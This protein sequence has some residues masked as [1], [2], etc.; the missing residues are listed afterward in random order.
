VLIAAAATRPPRA[1]EG[2]PGQEGDGEADEP[3]EDDDGESD[4]DG[5]QKIK[6]ELSRSS[7]QTT[8]PPKNGAPTLAPS[9]SLPTNSGV[10]LL[11]NTT[12]AFPPFP[13]GFTTKQDLLQAPLYLL[14]LKEAEYAQEQAAAAAA[15][16]GGG[17]P[18]PMY[19]A[20]H[21]ASRQVSSQGCSR[22][23]IIKGE[24]TGQLW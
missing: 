12:P 8:S 2:G 7:G 1:D 24:W 4:S 21:L 3:D 15:A 11:P 10:P 16:A 13:M 20:G 5:P 22:V 14:P 9:L 17:V 6:S 19:L 23:F 18:T